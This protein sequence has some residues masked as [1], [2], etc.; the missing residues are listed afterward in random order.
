MNRKQCWMGVV[1]AA[2]V[3]ILAAGCDK[4]G[5]PTG[6]APTNT[7]AKSSVETFIDGATGKTAVD[8]QRAAQDKIRKL[9][10]EHNKDLEEV[11]K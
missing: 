4:G 11:T 6:A 2:A 8:Q 5:Q 3:T 10:S 9:S 7:A 1:S